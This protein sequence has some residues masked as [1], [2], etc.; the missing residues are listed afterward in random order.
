VSG[1]IFKHL[2]SRFSHS[3]VRASGKKGLPERPSTSG[4][5]ALGE[6]H[7]HEEIMHMNTSS[8]IRPAWTPAT[9]ALV[10]L[11]FMLFWPIGLA[12][13]GY[14]LFGDRLEAF[15]RD[16]N[17][18]VDK[19]TGAFRG[20]GF[21]RPASTGNVAFDEWRDAE[22]ERLNNERRK[23]DELRADFEEELRELRR[24]KDKEDFDRFMAKRNA[25]ATKTR[26]S[27]PD[28]RNG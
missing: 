7:M 10:V 18:T 15:K 16:A 17:A 12:M 2:E 24:A 25:T 11:G 28:T 19:M 20:A 5:A 26:K 23:L 4:Q 8:L 21:A 22:I 3:Y 6:G 9:V 27:V 13:L 14:V 1:Y